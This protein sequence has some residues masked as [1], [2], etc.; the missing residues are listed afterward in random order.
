MGFLC[1]GNSFRG[2]DLLKLPWAS[3]TGK[4]IAVGKSWPGRIG[5][6][7]FHAPLP[8]A[9]L[10]RRWANEAVGLVPKCSLNALLKSLG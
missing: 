10:P 3:A 1:M 2:G 7:G 5:L 8:R 4:G 9:T 6:L